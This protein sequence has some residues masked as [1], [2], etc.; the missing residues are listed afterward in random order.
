MR[1]IFGLKGKE[2]KEVLQGKAQCRDWQTNITMV[3]SHTMGWDWHVAHT[4]GKK[5]SYWILKDFED[6]DVVK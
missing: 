6:R 1:R 4:E 5:N 3:L 2:V